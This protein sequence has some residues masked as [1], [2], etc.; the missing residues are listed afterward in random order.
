MGANIS[1]LGSNLLTVEGVDVKSLRSTEHRVLADMIEVGSFI[2][3]AAM[4]GSELT[5][6]NADV[7][8]LGVIPETFK[9][10][11]IQLEI[12][13]S[14]IFIPYQ[15]KYKI[16]KFMDGSIL[17]IYDH[18][19]PG[20]TPDLLSIALVVATQAKGTVLFHQKM[21]ESRLF[22]IDRLIDMG[23]Q[24]VLCDPHRAVVV[25]LNKETPLRRNTMVSPDIRAG[26]ALL[27][28]AMSADGKSKIQNINQID[29]GYEKI[30][31]RLNALGADIRRV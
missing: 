23:A 3:L 8:H 30:D 17:T 29:R 25:G 6:K 11:G 14:D 27:I 21:F 10:L 19:W 7:K 31:E 13:G 16:T 1:G 28:A 5:I 18:P 24:I 22:F 2:G 26:L 12:Q 20:F 15:E 9:K 4:T